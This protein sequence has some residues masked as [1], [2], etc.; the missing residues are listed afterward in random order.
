MGKKVEGNWEQVSWPEALGTIADNLNQIKEKH[1]A[2]QFEFDDIGH[3]GIGHGY[4]LARPKVVDPPED[5]WPD[6]KILTELGKLMTPKELWPDD[7]RQLLEDLVK[8]AGLTYA[9][10]VEKGYLKG[11][12][13]FRAYLGYRHR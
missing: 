9:Q 1:G 13:R 6:M 4:I 8:P 10:F 2:S 5:C 3:Y 12:D 7:Y 11:P